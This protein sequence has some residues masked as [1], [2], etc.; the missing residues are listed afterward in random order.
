MKLE[1]IIEKN[2]KHC[3]NNW[4]SVISLGL[5]NSHYIMH[6]YTNKLRLLKVSTCLC[7]YSCRLT[8]TWLGCHGLCPRHKPTELA[9][10]PFSSVLVSV[11]V[12]MALSTVFHSINS[13]DNSP[14]FHSVLL[15]L[16]LPYC[17]FQLYISSCKSP[18][19]LT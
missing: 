17:S 14:H 5:H 15:V 1:Y 19:A 7:C 4:Q 12:F 10:S 9:H 8:F 11:S 2:G 6:F 18:S 3:I 13:P 16:F